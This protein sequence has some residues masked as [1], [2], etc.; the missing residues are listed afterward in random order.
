MSA[1]RESGAGGD[2]TIRP[3]VA[4][5]APAILAC[6]RGIAEY[7]KLSHQVAATEESIRE[8]LFGAQPAA[9]TLIAHA[10]DHVAGF[11]VFFPTYSTFLARRGLWLEDIFVFP[12]WRGRGL[13]RRLFQAVA[14]LAAERGCGRFEWAVLDWNEPAIRF[15]ERAGA[16][17]HQGWTIYRMTAEDL[18]DLPRGE[19]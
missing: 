16:R 6:V 4:A 11:A 8:S 17:R 19:G 14:R 9:E 5:D 15:Y 1:G 3:A 12:R 2:F 7:E 13:G 18:R 10:G